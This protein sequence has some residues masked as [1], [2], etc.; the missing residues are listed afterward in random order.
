[1]LHHLFRMTSYGKGYEPL[2]YERPAFIDS[3]SEIPILDCGEVGVVGWHGWISQL[4]FSRKHPWWGTVGHHQQLQ[5]EL[6]NIRLQRQV[7]KTRRC[8]D[9]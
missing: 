2:S 9:T 1:M 8:R 3:L 7:I 5:L 6:T 4:H